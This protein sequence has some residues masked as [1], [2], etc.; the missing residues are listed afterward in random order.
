MKRLLIILILTAAAG[1]QTWLA[2]YNGPANDEDGARSIAV[3]ATGAIYVTGSSW[4]IGTEKDWA[5]AKY[6]AAGESLWLMRF[7]GDAHSS[8]EAYALALG[9]DRVIV[10]GGRTAANFMTDMYTVAYNSAGVQQWAMPLDGRTNGNDLGLAATVDADGNVYVAGYSS[11]TTGWD[12]TLVK[13]SPAG[14]ELWVRRYVT[15]DE[16][17][18]VAVATDASGNVYVTGSS[19]SPYYLTWDYITLKFD[20][21]GTRHWVARYNDP[22]NG[23][24]E[25]K[26]MVLDAD[27][28]VYVTGTSE[29]ATT[30][31]DIVT[32]KYLP[33]GDTAWVRRYDGPAVG[34]DA[35]NAIARGPDNSIYV[36]GCC[37]DPVND[38]DFATLKYDAAGNRQWIA[39][40]DGAAHSYDEARALVVDA[41]GNAYVTGTTT[42]PESRADYLTIKYTPTGNR[43]W[44]YDYDNAVTGQDEAYAIALDSADGVCVTGMSAGMFSGL[45][46][47]TLRYLRTGVAESPSYDVRRPSLAVGPNPVRGNAVIRYEL[48]RPGRVRLEIADAAGRVLS[49]PVDRMEAAGTHRVTC[50]LHDLPEGVY[51]VRLNVG[52]TS[53]AIGKLVRMR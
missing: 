28:N 7:D 15:P 27:G 26:G 43:E 20:R 13:Y 9:P 6:S 52:G 33:S 8:D 41:A 23:P 32:V 42:D 36:T 3:D 12:L 17:Y 2:R 24:D 16:D 44:T 47:L 46:Y 4:G 50:P 10:T 45:D 19:G 1:A 14:A 29:G 48:A 53:A 31:R 21:D 30:S 51:L 49:M 34:P 40:Y 25:A 39:T 11:D 18:A 22:S 5:T 38:L 37:L 35:A